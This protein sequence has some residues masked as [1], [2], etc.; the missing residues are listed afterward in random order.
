MDTMYTTE[1]PCLVEDSICVL[2]TRATS[3]CASWSGSFQE[4]LR[5]L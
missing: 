3:V 2:M 5:N 1:R 4:G